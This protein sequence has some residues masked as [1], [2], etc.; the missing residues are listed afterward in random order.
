MNLPNKDI[1]IRVAEDEE[2]EANT[3]YDPNCC[4]WNDSDENDTDE[5]IWEDTFK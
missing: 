1:P 3:E 4:V 2:V 5:D